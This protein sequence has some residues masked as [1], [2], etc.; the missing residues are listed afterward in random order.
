MPD[1]FVNRQSELDSPAYDAFPITANGSELSTWTRSVYVGNGGT[2]VAVM[3]SGGTAT[4]GNV[5]DG[6]LLPIR[7][8]AIGAAS[9]ASGLVGLA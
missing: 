1:L 7:V 9:T 3:A 8:R 2:V 5:G 6:Q 4:F